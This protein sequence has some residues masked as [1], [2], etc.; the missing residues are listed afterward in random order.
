MPPQYKLPSKDMPMLSEARSLA[1]SMA[2]CQGWQIPS[3]FMTQSHYCFQKLELSYGITG[4]SGTSFPWSG[5]THKAKKV[6]SC[7]PCF[8]MS[9]LLLWWGTMPGS[10][11]QLSSD[12]IE[13]SAPVTTLPT[14]TLQGTSVSSSNVKCR[15]TSVALVGIWVFSESLKLNTGVES[16]QWPVIG[17]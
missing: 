2:L 5:N 4:F 6:V 7:F 9:V 14:D 13:T 10:F 3:F 1:S 17:K 11:R 8:F 15:P 12:D 16:Y